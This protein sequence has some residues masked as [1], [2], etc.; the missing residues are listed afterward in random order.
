MC[1]LL[2]ILLLGL[3]VQNVLKNYRYVGIPIIYF[4]D[5]INS[6]SILDIS[7]VDRYLC[8]SYQ[9]GHSCECPSG[10]KYLSAVN[11][12]LGKSQRECR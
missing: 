9:G 3:G 5:C 10:F 8:D 2:L 12:C 4:S 1:F 7:C 6:E 11:E